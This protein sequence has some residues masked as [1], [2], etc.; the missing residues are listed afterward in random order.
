M[1]NV[2]KCKGCGGQ[3]DLVANICA[4]CDAPLIAY[5]EDKITDEE[6]IESTGKW[7]A[8]FIENLNQNSVFGPNGFFGEMFN[9]KAMQQQRADM[10]KKGVLGVMKE[11]YTGSDEAPDVWDGKTAHYSTEEI[12]VNTS[13]CISMLVSRMTSNPTL[14]P[15]HTHFKGEIEKAEN[16]LKGKMKIAIACGIALFVFLCICYIGIFASQMGK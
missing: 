4:Y 12:K 10:Q 16:S 3:N 1:A 6:L 13:K 14:V 15:I 5:S 9:A 8:L 2:N 7:V 11:A